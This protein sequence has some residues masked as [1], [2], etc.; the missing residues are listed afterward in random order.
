M[1]FVYTLASS[2]QCWSRWCMCVCA[3][4]MKVCTLMIGDIHLVVGYTT[5]IVLLCYFIQTKVIKYKSSQPICVLVSIFAYICERGICM[6]CMCIIDWSAIWEHSVYVLV[7]ERVRV[8]Y[9]T[10]LLAC[11]YCVCVWMSMCVCVCVCVCV[12][13]WACVCV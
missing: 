7:N 11:L 9:V 8:F 10:S 13:K 6:L 1:S 4:M 2:C 3:V 12:C 5:V